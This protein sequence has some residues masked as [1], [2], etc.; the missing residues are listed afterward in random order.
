MIKIPV[1]QLSKV[2][3]II[4]CNV[5]NVAFAGVCMRIRFL[6]FRVRSLLYSPGIKEVI[7]FDLGLRFSCEWGKGAWV[8]C[9]LRKR[10]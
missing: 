3:G 9:T 5:F 4:C 1:T 6:S 10:R 2:A 8:S 7:A